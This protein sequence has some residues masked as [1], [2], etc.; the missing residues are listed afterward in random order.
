[1]LRIEAVHMDNRAQF[2]RYAADHGSEHDDSYLPGSGFDPSPEHPAYLLLHGD[3]VVGAAS[4]MRT[5]RYLQAGRS[6]F[7][8]F[9]STDPSVQAYTLLFGAIRRHFDGL[10][11]V[12]LFLP[13]SRVGAA[14]A[15]RRLGFSVE[16]YSYIMVLRDVNP[17]G[18][19]VPEG[20]ALH[21]IRPMDE[22]LFREFARET[23][24]NFGGLAG[25]LPMPDDELRQWF[26]DETYLEDGIV[27]LLH[28]DTP[29]GT[30]CVMHEY[31][32]RKAAGISALSVARA[33]RHKGLGRLLL[34]H[35]V[36]FA[37]WRGLQPVFLSLNAEN[38]RALQLYQSEGFM[39]TNKV[40]C[41]SRDCERAAPA[42][43]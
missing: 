14:D 2:I 7:S 37:A 19:T 33:H 6:R 4:L 24:A 40:I 28:G 41:F 21:P 9:H 30:V 25:H 18:L 13:E 31:E 15:V 23:N 22:H 39:V 1:M 5:P 20:Y 29:V 11:S 3:V 43:P 34:K 32:D 38:D 26:T 17:G 12:N 36:C 8:I 42:S 10:R 35:A 27:L 16:R